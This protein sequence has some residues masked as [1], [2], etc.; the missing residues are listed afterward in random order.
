MIKWL[1]KRSLIWQ[2]DLP[3]LHPRDTIH[4]DLGCGVSPK[5]PLK[6]EKVLGIDLTL[7]SLS[8]KSDTAQAE[9]FRAHDITQGLPFESQAFDSVS[10]F[11]FLEHVPRW[12]RVNQGI[13]F[14]FVN[15][16]AEIYRVLKPGGYFLALTPAVPNSSAFTDPTH[17]NFITIDTASYFCSTGGSIPSGAMYGY[18]GNFEIIHNDWLKGGGPNL[19]HSLTTKYLSTDSTLL[20]KICIGLKFSKRI[21]KLHMFRNPSHIYWVFQKK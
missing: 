13:V 4:L 14:P 21:L 15:L 12:E 10:A 11:D 18:V 3:Y 19:N 16:M 17:V 9:S 8:V 6:A 20:Q 7:P 1:R 2:I 5:N